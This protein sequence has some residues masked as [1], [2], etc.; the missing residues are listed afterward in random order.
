MKI[1]LVV[2][3]FIALPLVTSAQNFEETQHQIDSG[4]AVIK[5][6]KDN[7]E[8]YSNNNIKERLR[9]ELGYLQVDLKEYIYTRDGLVACLKNNELDTSSKDCKIAL[10]KFTQE[11]IRLKNRYSKI[12]RYLKTGFAEA[13]SLKIQEIR[14]KTL[15]P[16]ETGPTGLS[17]LIKGNII[18]KKDLESEALEI[19]E[20]LN[21]SMEDVKLIIK[22]LEK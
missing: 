17:K 8:T 21:E 7:S 19:R 13:V 1:N 10:I 22:E 14:G 9:R 15:Q 4:V 5:T 16:K 3:V 2:L 6:L 18:E 12:S 11:T 20:S